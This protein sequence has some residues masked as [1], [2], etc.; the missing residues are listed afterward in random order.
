MSIGQTIES[1]GKPLNKTSINT[2]EG[3]KEVWEYQKYTLEFLNGS[4]SKIIYK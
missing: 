2:D 1:I 4:L 3:I